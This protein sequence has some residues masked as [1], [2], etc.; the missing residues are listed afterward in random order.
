MATLNWGK[1]KLETKPS[2]GGAPKEHVEWKK[3]DTPK[4]GTTKI[5][6]TEGNVTEALEEGGGVVDSRTE[7]SK[8]KLEFDLFVKK[9]VE[10]PFTDVDGVI[11]GE[12]AFRLIPEDP[13][14]KGYLIDR[15]QVAVTE[16]FTS[17]E[18][19]LMHYVIKVLKPKE[20]EF[21]KKQVISV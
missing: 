2:E 12:H 20:G 6:T 3:I 11:Q 7:Q 17:A 9:D 16:S 18:G 19:G 21:L 15:A 10:P 5:D 4:N 13:T 1:M 14:A 8:Y